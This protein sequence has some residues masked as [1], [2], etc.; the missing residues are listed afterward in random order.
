MK[1]AKKKVYIV[2]DLMSTIFL[3][4]KL[5]YIVKKLKTKN[6]SVSIFMDGLYIIISAL[7]GAVITIRV[8]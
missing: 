8:F 6:H 4:V 1:K 3:E 2:L 7:I 5:K